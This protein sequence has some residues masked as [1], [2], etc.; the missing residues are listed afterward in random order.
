MRFLADWSLVFHGG[1]SSCLQSNSS[2][3]DGCFAAADDAGRAP[4]LILTML[5]R[6]RRPELVRQIVINQETTVMLLA[7]L[8]SCPSMSEPDLLRPGASELGSF[9]HACAPPRSFLRLPS[10]TLCSS[11]SSLLPYFK[12]PRS[13]V[14]SSLDTLP[15]DILNTSSLCYPPFAGSWLL[16]GQILDP[17]FALLA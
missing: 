5:I 13:P 17:T 2:D 15:F 12:S 3:D 11:I 4:S 7:G 16:T 14:P 6:Q 10:L 1:T 8:W 9:S